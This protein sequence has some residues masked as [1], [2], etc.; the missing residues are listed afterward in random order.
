MRSQILYRLTQFV[1]TLFGVSLVSFLIV[2][3]SPV[4]PVRAMFAASGNIPSEE[5]MQAMR[6]EW[7]LDKSFFEQYGSWLWRA[8]QGDFGT[9]FSQGAP[10]SALLMAR[11]WPTVYLTFLSLIMMIALAIPLGVISALYHNKIADYI[12]RFITFISISMPNFWL[13]LILLYVAALKLRIINVVSTQIDFEKLFL[14]ALTLAIAM[15]GKY[16]RQVRAA[17]LEE[18]NQDYVIGARAL[19]LSERQVLWKHIMPNAMLPLITLFGLSIGSLLG[20]TAVVEII[21]SVPALGSLAITAITAMD[22]PLIQGYV[23]WI[24][25]IYMLV[26]FIVDISYGYLDPRIKLKRL[27]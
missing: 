14:P 9:S 24:A 21:F 26:N 10:V 16:A 12:V 3:L 13:G 11:L 20:G 5:V 23:L 6:V 25:L 22:Y 17:I 15:A 2:Y 8:L 18:V 19:G 27:S 1:L 4:D 7:G